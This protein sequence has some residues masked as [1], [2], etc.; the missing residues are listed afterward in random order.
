[1]IGAY[2]ASKR[3]LQTLVESMG[4]ELR[5]KGINV[6]AVLPSIIDTPANRRDM[7]KADP[8]KWVAPGDLAKVILFLCSD[9]AKPIHGVALPVQGLS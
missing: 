5:A 7:P 1:M 2:A 8:A 6:N 3:A 9:D 4:A